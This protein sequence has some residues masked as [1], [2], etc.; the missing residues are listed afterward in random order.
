MADEEALGRE[1]ILHEEIG[2]GAL[3]VVRRATSRDGGPPLAAKLLKPEYTADRRMRELFI[4][5]EAALRDLEHPSIVG[6]RDLVVERGRLALL[7]D[8]VDGPNLRRFL[9]DRGGRLPAAQASS[10][11]MQAAAALAAAHAQGVV[12]LD[13]KPENILVESG[14]DP[15]R[16]RISDFGVAALLL[17]AD[18]PVLG[19]TPGYEAPEVQQ[20]RAPTAAADVYGLGVVLRELL[21]GE[22][23]PRLAAVVDRCLDPDPRNRPSARALAVQLR[24]APPTPLR[25]EHEEKQG[26]TRLRNGGAPRPAAEPPAT[27]PTAARQPWRRGPLITV[28]AGLVVATVFAVMTANAAADQPRAA[29][30][31]QP[32]AP[33]IAPASSSAPVVS[34]PP[35]DK[36]AQPV[37]RTRATF[38]GKVDNGGGTLAVSIRDGV[39]IAYICDG[40]KVE[41]WLKG[42]AAAGKLTLTGENGAKLTGAFDED[43]ASGRVTVLGR[44]RSFTIGVAEKPSGL[45]RAAAQVRDA[46]VRGSWIVLQDG[47]QVGV[48]TTDEAPAPA[49]E[50]D[51]TGRTTTVGETT[52][53]A[54]TIDVDTGE[55]F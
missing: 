31:G 11:A 6:I 15:V 42:T 21:G 32:I 29:N 30:V 33:G 43:G 37:D 17:D 40:K 10:I 50:L 7:M 39:A 26:D 25:E 19:G 49:P 13:L 41:A 22:V 52:V 9:A 3:A 27:T 48:L 45:Y 28:A 34:L 23:P 46:E 36:L 44:T 8:Y 55:G 18:R 24:E 5:E 14:T 4:R 12:H 38:A 35:T 54:S 51:V 53:T 2:R 20:G 16:I 47:S 1:Y